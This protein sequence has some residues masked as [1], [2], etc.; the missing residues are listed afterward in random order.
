MPEQSRYRA[1]DLEE[2][3]DVLTQR[4]LQLNLSR[5]LKQAVQLELAKPDYTLAQLEGNT[6]SA[7]NG[8]SNSPLL[9]NLVEKM[10]I[11]RCLKRAAID[12]HGEAIHNAE[13]PPQTEPK[14]EAFLTPEM[15][16]SNSCCLD[17]VRQA[18]DNWN[19][20]TKEELVRF[21]RESGK[22]LRLP[23]GRGVEIT[24][25]HS[26]RERSADVDPTVRAKRLSSTRFLYDGL[27]NT[28][29]LCRVKP[30]T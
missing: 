7:V 28:C 22:P 27:V 20:D 19:A 6:R 26:D 15:Q 4:L 2:K 16:W 21:S 18:R 25:E 12:L 11:A 3:V 29:L 24:M 14:D 13:I 23:A 30:T 9:L 8:G 10:G 17:A 5:E 1:A